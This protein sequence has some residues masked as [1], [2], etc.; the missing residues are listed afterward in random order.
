MIPNQPSTELTDPLRKG[1][2][3]KRLQGCV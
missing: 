3:P 2:M 1:T